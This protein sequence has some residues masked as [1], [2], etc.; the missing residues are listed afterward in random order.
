MMPQPVP[1]LARGMSLCQAPL[2]GSF[3]VPTEVVSLTPYITINKIRVKEPKD[4]C[5]D[6]ES[7]MVKPLRAPGMLLKNWSKAYQVLVQMFGSVKQARMIEEV[8]RCQ[9]VYG[10]AYPSARFLAAGALADEKTWD[11][12]LAMLREKGYA[13][14]ART[15]R[16]GGKLSVNL[17]DLRAL[18]GIILSFLQAKARSFQHLSSGLWVKVHGAWMRTEQLP[19]PGVSSF[20]AAAM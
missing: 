17:I 9:A 15:H 1:T 12:C 18:W 11:R 19:L 5:R 13:V 10:K 20:G 8:L 16:L 4:L 3:N 14:T 2:P 6:I 7:K